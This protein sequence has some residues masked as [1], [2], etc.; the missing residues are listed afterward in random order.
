MFPL[1]L[2]SYLLRSWFCL[3]MGQFQGPQPLGESPNLP[4]H[5]GAPVQT[6]KHPLVGAWTGPARGLGVQRI[7]GTCA[8]PQE[9][10]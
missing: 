8:Q 4:H 3:V 1:V 5:Q 7:M 2:F 10:Q 9:G 6:P